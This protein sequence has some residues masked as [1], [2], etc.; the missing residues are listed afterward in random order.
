[1]FACF[2]E[3]NYPEFQEGCTLQFIT[4]FVAL[5]VQRSN[6][7]D[8]T[9]LRG[10][11]RATLLHKR[12]NINFLKRTIPDPDTLTPPTIEVFFGEEE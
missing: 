12:H 3:K 7:D 6:K 9:L 10:I 2:L 4:S 8:K 11:K 1:M 5:P